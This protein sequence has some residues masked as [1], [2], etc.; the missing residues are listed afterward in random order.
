VV[1]DYYWHDYVP[2]RDDLHTYDESFLLG[3]GESM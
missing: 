1:Q 2:G 3:N